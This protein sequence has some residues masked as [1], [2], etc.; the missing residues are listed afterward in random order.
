[1]R[2]LPE[3]LATSLIRSSDTFPRNASC[4]FCDGYNSRPVE[5]VRQYRA[6][7]S[8]KPLEQRKLIRLAHGD[9]PNRGP[10]W[11]SKSRLRRLGQA[12]GGGDQGESTPCR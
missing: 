12:P 10:A 7:L 2:S 11:S 4:S 3:C 5:R 1:M 8:F 9:R 6:G